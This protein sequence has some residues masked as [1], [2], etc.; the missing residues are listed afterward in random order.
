MYGET[1]PVLTFFYQSNSC[2]NTGL[3][4]FEAVDCVIFRAITLHVK[5]QRKA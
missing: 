3:R 2:Y 4:L 5:T 1:P